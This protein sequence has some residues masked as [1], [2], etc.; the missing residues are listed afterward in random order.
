MIKFLLVALFLVL[1]VPSVNANE[2]QT[3]NW[4]IVCKNVAVS[5]TPVVE[6]IRVWNEPSFNNWDSNIVI[7]FYDKKTDTNNWFFYMG[8]NILCKTMTREYYESGR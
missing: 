2:D 7:R 6:T 5:G 8:P 3:W 1:F 4:I